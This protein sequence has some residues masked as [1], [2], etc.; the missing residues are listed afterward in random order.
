[1]VKTKRDVRGSILL[2]LDEYLANPENFTSEQWERME[3]RKA[4]S[5]IE[6]STKIDP[7]MHVAPKSKPES[8]KRENSKYKNNW[9]SM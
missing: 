8:K 1:M 7:T 4:I 9:I 3:K 2:S 6:P 5:G